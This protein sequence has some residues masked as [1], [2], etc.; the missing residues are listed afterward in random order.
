MKTLK[1]STVVFDIAVND[2]SLPVKAT[3]FVIATGETRIR[4]SCN[5]SPVHIFGWNNNKHQFSEI[6]IQGDAFPPI[7]AMAIAG[8]L[9]H[10]FEMIKHAA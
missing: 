2:R 4:V 5:N 1:N 3:P 9:E 8:N 6:E 10:Q 7:I